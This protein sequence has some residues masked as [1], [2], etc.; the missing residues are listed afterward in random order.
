MAL[1]GEIAIARD[2]TLSGRLEVGV[3][4][5]MIA[6]ANT[7]RLKTMFGPSKEGF[8]WITLKISGSAS[9]PMD[10]FKELFLSARTAVVPAAE[11][12]HEES[13]FEELTKPR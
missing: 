7:P 5:N 2:Q 13:T 9:A 3:A 10:N 1:R 11:P 4:G 6:S 12:E 8:Q